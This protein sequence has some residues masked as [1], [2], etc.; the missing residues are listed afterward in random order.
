MKHRVLHAALGEAGPFRKLGMT[1]TRRT[2]L[3][4]RHQDQVDQEGG[5]AVVVADQ[6]PHECVHNVRIHHVLPVAHRYSTRRVG[7]PR[8]GWSQA[9]ADGVMLR[10]VNYVGIPTR[11]QDRALTF[12]TET[13]GCIITTDRLVGEKRWIEL[14]IP[15][16]QTGLLLLTPEG[17]ENRVGTFFN[18]S[19]G[20]DDVQYTYEKLIA[21]GVEFLGSPEKRPFPHV[22]FKDP[23]GNTFLLSSR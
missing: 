3:G 11:D 9:G 16:A 14:T 2:F 7:R 15:G 22:Y 13:M 1:E 23:D 18:G 20:C 17:H 10:R 8:K 12:W 6:I 19:F 4:R 5:W 21:R